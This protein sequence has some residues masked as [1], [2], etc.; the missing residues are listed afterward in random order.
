MAKRSEYTSSSHNQPRFL[1]LSAS[2]YIY[3]TKI[4]KTHTSILFNWT[5]G[6][7]WDICEVIDGCLQASVSIREQFGDLL[8][9]IIKIRISKVQTVRNGSCC[10]EFECQS[11]ELSQYLSARQPQWFS[12]LSRRYFS[13]CKLI[14]FL[15]LVYRICQ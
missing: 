11:V 5:P 2:L 7:Q 15:V 3:H 9:Q 8:I 14:C 12:R 4:H 6:N 10:F 1:F 13:S